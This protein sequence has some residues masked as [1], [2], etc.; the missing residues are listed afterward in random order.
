MRLTGN[1]ASGQALQDGVAFVLGGSGTPTP[2][3]TYVVAADS[4]YLQPNGFSGTAEPLTTIERFKDADLLEREEARS[5]TAAI[6]DQIAQGQVSAENPLYVFGYSQS[7]AFS[8]FTMEQLHADGVAS[9]D[10]HFVL[11]GCPVAPDGG[12][13]TRFDIP[14][15]TDAISPINNTPLGN[16]LPDNLYPTDVYTLEYDPV[17]DFPRY[18]L[19][20]L[21][22]L[23][24][25]IGLFTEH[26]TYL[27][28]TPEQVATAV[29]LATSGDTLVNYHMIPAEYLPLLVPL[30]LVPVIGIPLYDLLEPDMRIL[31]NLGYGSITQG[32]DA[33]PA[34][35]ETPIS[36]APP[37]IPISDVANALSTGLTEGL[38]AAIKDLQDPSIY[39]L[40]P[41]VDN[42]VLAT[43]IQT[44]AVYGGDPHPSSILEV[45]AIWL[46]AFQTAIGMG[47]DAAAAAIPD[48]AGP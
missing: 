37:D 25:F 42:P 5:L 8:P 4:L 41:L 6:H 46:Q 38:D 32:W 11:I 10:V 7:A 21:S 9:G 15:G 48:F 1:N 47:S 17:A 39:Q 36:L 33:G 35:V 20:L 29:P 16:A 45:L 2:P 31:V 24:A 26:L 40:T 22:D 34:N 28:L 23:N 14:P 18:P 12:L 3:P 30:R 43:L 44:Q 19:D 13:Y 27:G